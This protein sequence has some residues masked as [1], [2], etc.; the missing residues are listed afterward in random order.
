M[1]WEPHD[2]CPE[3]TL[4]S[5]IY[6][7]YPTWESSSRKLP[8]KQLAGGKSSSMKRK[9]QQ[10]EEVKSE[11]ALEP[12]VPP[13]PSYSESVSASSPDCLLVQEE[14]MLVL[15]CTV[16]A[17]ANTEHES[18]FLRWSP[19]VAE[20][21]ERWDVFG[22]N[23]TYVHLRIN[24]SNKLSQTYPHMAALAQ[25]IVDPSIREYTLPKNGPCIKLQAVPQASRILSI[26][27]C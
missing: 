23:N 16:N 17:H 6:G 14:S 1:A 4:Y 22:K 27:L 25:W 13:P 24:R 19:R 26:T 21:L 18:F 10:Q 11:K 3:G 7:L 15:L 2:F 8:R 20:L 12:M 5:E 9:T